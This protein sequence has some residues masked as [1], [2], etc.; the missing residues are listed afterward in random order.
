MVV[1]I[2]LGAVGAASGF[3]WFLA[4]LAHDIGE[5]IGRVE[6][7]V[8]TL[9]SRIE[10]L[11]QS[12]DAGVS[13]GQSEAWLKLTRASFRAAL[14]GIVLKRPDGSDLHLGEAMAAAI[15]DLPERGK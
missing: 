6:Y 5:R 15:P 7:S 13:V 14:A 11:T 2:V 10:M 12:V 3:A 8:Q 4:G 9:G 1:S